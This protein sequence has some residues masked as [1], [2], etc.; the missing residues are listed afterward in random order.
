MPKTD[1]LAYRGLPHEHWKDLASTNSLKR[2][3]REIGRR[4]GVIS[5]FP[6]RPQHWGQRA[7]SRENAAVNGRYFSQTSLEKLQNGVSTPERLP[8]QVSQRV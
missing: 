8:E 4:A 3:N 1:I 7:P 2:L 6:I 5:I